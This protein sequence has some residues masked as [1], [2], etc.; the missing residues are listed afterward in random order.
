MKTT[1][2]DK[3]G[4]I[5][6]PNEIRRVLRIQEGEPLAISLDNENRIVIRKYSPLRELNDFAEQVCDSA[7]TATGRLAAICDLNSV[8]AA[9]AWAHGI[10]ADLAIDDEFTA[11][12]EDA[13]IYQHSNGKRVY[14]T[15]S[16]PTFHVVLAVPIL[17]AGNVIGYVASISD[18]AGATWNDTDVHLALM[19]AELIQFKLED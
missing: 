9:S 18:V 17:S 7:F 19:A 8:I 15:R 13:D 5:V 4:R 1:Y 14:L 11:I 2:I 10:L 3:L 16:N 12:M 6:I